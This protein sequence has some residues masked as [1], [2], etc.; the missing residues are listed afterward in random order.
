MLKDWL[1]TNLP[2]LVE[3]LVQEEIRRVSKEILSR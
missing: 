3:R 1:D 2:P